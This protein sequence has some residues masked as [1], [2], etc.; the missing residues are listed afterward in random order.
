MNADVAVADGAIPIMDLDTWADVT[1]YPFWWPGAV[2]EDPESGVAQF[3]IA[4]GNASEPT[5]YAAW[6]VHQ[7]S[8]GGINSA[9]T[10]TAIIASETQFGY[11]LNDTV[12]AWLRCV[13]KA[14][15][16]S[17]AVASTGATI[18]NEVYTVVYSGVD[19]NIFL[20]A[21]DSDLYADWASDPSRPDAFGYI[22]WLPDTIDGRSAAVFATSV[23]GEEQFLESFPTQAVFAGL[24]FKI[25]AESNVPASA[26]ESVPAVLAEDRDQFDLDNFVEV[27]LYYGTNMDA[28][29][30]YPTLVFFDTNTSTWRSDLCDTGDDTAEG[31]SHESSDRVAHFK[32]CH[33]TEYAFA[34]LPRPP[35]PLSASVDQ[36]GVNRVELS[37]TFSVEVDLN[38]VELILW[39]ITDASLVV[40]VINEFAIA[41]L[42]AGGEVTMTV[43]N[44]TTTEDTVTVNAVANG[45]PAGAW[46][47]AAGTKKEGVESALRLVDGTTNKRTVQFDS[48][49]SNPCRSNATCVHDEAVNSFVC[50][51]PP[52]VFGPLCIDGCEGVVCELNATCMDLANGTDYACD[53]PADSGR[54][55]P[56]CSDQ[57]DPNPCNDG[58]CTNS[59]NGPIC[60]C[61]DGVLGPFCLDECSFGLCEEGSTCV[62]LE[63]G[64]E[65]VCPNNITTPLCEDICQT[66]CGPGDCSYTSSA[67]WITCDCP[68]I[69][70]DDLCT[71]LEDQ[72]TVNGEPYCQNNGT[73]YYASGQ[74]L[75]DC[76]PAFRGQTCNLQISVC[77][78]LPADT[79]K[80]GAPCVDTTDARGYYCYCGV[81]FT[82]RHCDEPCGPLWEGRNCETPVEVEVVDNVTVVVEEEIYAPVAYNSMIVVTMIDAFEFKFYIPVIS[83]TTKVPAVTHMDLWMTDVNEEERFIYNGTYTGDVFTVFDVRR[84]K[85]TRCTCGLQMESAGALTRPPNRCCRSAPCPNAASRPRCRR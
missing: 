26:N 35:Q 19:Q 63:V 42:T 71:V 51:C 65:C 76:L 11:G 43:L 30:Y 8:V 78:N 61:P 29:N 46:A 12:H 39:Y 17:D 72:C 22:A 15:L 70:F 37:L 38:A 20:S 4:L 59:A 66:A 14:G 5:A 16:T 1:K 48:C 27:V 24:T 3:E 10:Y 55:P 57:C 77:D 68:D 75:C 40:P 36:L 53:C 7:D 28:V 13:N 62:D 44:T 33:F 74:A 54:F 64:F 21:T 60:D 79:C 31:T 41:E 81:G 58:T 25:A 80:N 50:V 67:P 2:C 56:D 9:G 83:P 49:V 18:T 6:A 34:F 23:H 84:V 73:C 82:G 85:D 32:V 47:L 45:I 52:G 69:Y